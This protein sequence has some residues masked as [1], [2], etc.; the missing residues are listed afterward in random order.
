MA[1]VITRGYWWFVCVIF[2]YYF[3][4][5]YDYTD[6]IFSVFVWL[7]RIERRIS[8][9]G[10]NTNKYFRKYK[11]CRLL[12]YLI[13]SLK[14]SF[15]DIPSLVR[16]RLLYKCIHI[17]GLFL[18]DKLLLNELLVLFYSWFIYCLLISQTTSKSINLDENTFLQSAYLLCN[19]IVYFRYKNISWLW[20]RHNYYEI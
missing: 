12:K 2:Y 10:L 16:I 9:Y 4:W 14:I 17:F 3:Y 18:L 1:A 15:L 5:A 6:F 19:I 7:Q 11:T 13:V 20:S 8:M